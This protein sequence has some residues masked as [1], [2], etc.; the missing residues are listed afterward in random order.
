MASWANVLTYIFGQT[1]Q[2]ENSE[3]DLKRWDKFTIEIWWYEEL[4]N[5]EQSVKIVTFAVLSNIIYDID[6]HA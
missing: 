4:Q 1:M 6:I 3:Y 5:F 2:V